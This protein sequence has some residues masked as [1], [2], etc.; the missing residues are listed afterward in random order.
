MKFTW[1]EQTFLPNEFLLKNPGTNQKC[2]KPSRKSSLAFAQVFSSHK[3]AAFSFS[4]EFS[5]SV[6]HR[7]CVC[8][9]CV[10]CVCAACGRPQQNLKLKM[11]I[12]NMKICTFQ[13]D[14]HTHARTHAQ[15]EKQIHKFQISVRKYLQ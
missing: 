15:N 11:C 4:L 2:Q 8:V 14:T 12:N 13:R 7:M 9:S 10:S 1:D 5:K 6:S 3:Y